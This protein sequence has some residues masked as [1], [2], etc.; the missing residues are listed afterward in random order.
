MGELDLRFVAFEEGF[1]IALYPPLLS[2]LEP[3]EDRISRTISVK[4]VRIWSRKW[5]STW[6]RNSKSTI[7]HC[8][9]FKPKSR[10]I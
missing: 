1:D 3:V 2:F 10:G 4:E 5:I 7:H 9:R 6:N 8:E